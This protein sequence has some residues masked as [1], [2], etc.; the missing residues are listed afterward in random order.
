MACM[1]YASD[2]LKAKTFELKKTDPP[3]LQEERSPLL[4]AAE[5]GASESVTL[6]LEAHADTWAVGLLR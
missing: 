2:V 5:H 3:N 4:V 1:L 6:L